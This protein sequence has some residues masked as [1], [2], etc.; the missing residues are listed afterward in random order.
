MAALAREAGLLQQVMGDEIDDPEQ[1]LEQLFRA[2]RELLVVRTMAGQSREV[3]GRMAAALVRVIPRE[4]QPLVAHLAGQLE[5]VRGLADGEK[6]FL[7]GV[8]EFYQTRTDTKMTIAAER[9]AVIAAV[10]LP[11]TGLSSIY[12]IN[13][14][15]NDRTR[16]LQLA[17][18]L[19]VMAVMSA[20][21]LRW[22]KQQGWW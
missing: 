1:F 4:A 19:A 12:G 2:R 5:R 9:L 3:Y 21:L 17:V 8:I 15:V 13:V 14:I 10:T 16:Y 22:T 18:L 11:I 6:D 7:H 20:A